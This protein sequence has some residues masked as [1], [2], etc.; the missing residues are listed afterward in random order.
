MARKLIAELILDPSQYIRG[1]RKAERA[2]KEFTASQDKV[3]GDQPYWLALFKR[4][5]ALYQAYKERV[6]RA[7]E[8]P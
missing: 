4:M 5:Y 2:S 3:F 6:M 7:P 1:L 8:E